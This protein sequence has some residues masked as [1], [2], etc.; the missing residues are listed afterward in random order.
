MKSFP[1]RVSITRRSDWYDN[2]GPWYQMSSWCNENFGLEN[3]NIYS[4]EFLFK[5]EADMN[6][7]ILRWS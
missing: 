6:W 7:F 3:W 1:Y 5:K 4:N 2:E